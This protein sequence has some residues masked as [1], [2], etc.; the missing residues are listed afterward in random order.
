MDLGVKVDLNA[1]VIGGWINPLRILVLLLH[2]KLENGDLDTWYS[3]HPPNYQKAPLL[4]SGM[5]WIDWENRGGFA[6]GE[7]LLL[8]HLLTTDA[9]SQVRENRVTELFCDCFHTNSNKCSP[10]LGSKHTCWHCIHYFNP[11]S[12]AVMCRAR[13]G[14]TNF[15]RV[16]RCLSKGSWALLS[17]AAFSSL[18]ASPFKCFPQNQ[19]LPLVPCV[20]WTYCEH[21]CVP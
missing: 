17:P 3:P 9:Y 2:F 12:S 19:P 16:K 7:E 1:A 18:A 14:R 13:F 20:D 10:C 11:R 4:L 5:C 8:G 21:Y 6:F 15:Y